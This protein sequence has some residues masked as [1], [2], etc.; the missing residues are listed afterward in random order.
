MPRGLSEKRPIKCL[1]GPLKGI[2][3]YLRCPGLSTGP[4][5]IKGNIGV[6]VNGKWVREERA[7]VK[8][9]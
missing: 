5:D 2:T 9:I 4:I 1:D 8:K 3:L 7:N 6:Y